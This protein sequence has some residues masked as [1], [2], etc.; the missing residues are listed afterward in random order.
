MKRAYNTID[1][2]KMFLI[3]I[4]DIH[5]TEE[6]NVRKTT[7]ETGA[8][9]N[10]IIEKKDNIVDDASQE[11]VNATADTLRNFIANFKQTLFTRF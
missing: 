1:N 10:T 4:N 2:K 9:D 7:E 8:V 6:T 3:L 5:M 11:L